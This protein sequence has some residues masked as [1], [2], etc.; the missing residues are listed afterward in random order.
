MKEPVKPRRRYDS[1]RRHAQA[2]QT[3]QD[4]VAAAQRLFLERGFAGATLASIARSAGVAVETVYRSFGSKAALFK[5]VVEAAVAGGAARAT[6]PPEQRPVIQAMIAEPDP[7]RKLEMHAATQPG[8]HA[9]AGPLLRVLAQ[10][11]STDPSLADLL[12]QI[13]NQRLQG[14]GR[15]AEDLGKLGVLR[16]GI[17]VEEARD[18]LWMIN[19]SAVHELLVVQRGWS[20][21]RYRDLIASLE[22]RAILAQSKPPHDDPERTLEGENGSP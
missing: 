18:I 13:E 1:R 19:S 8:I 22:A 16:P 7:R 4:I 10:A 14:M 12:A 11:A 3:R 9:R 5:A 17:S 6:V 2:A 15:F 21:E 20:A